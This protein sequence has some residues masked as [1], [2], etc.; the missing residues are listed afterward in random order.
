MK[1]KE[2]QTFMS[3]HNPDIFVPEIQEIIFG[4]ESWW[5]EIRSEEDFKRI[6]DEDIQN[7]WYVKLM[8]QMAEKEAVEKSKEEDT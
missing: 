3:G 2:L 7:V 5:D 4:M 6:T 1:K 8:N